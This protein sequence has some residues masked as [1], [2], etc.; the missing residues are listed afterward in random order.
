MRSQYTSIRTEVYPSPIISTG[1]GSFT[2]AVAGTYYFFLS[3][4]NRVGLCELSTSVSATVAA[5]GALSITIPTTARR[6]GEDIQRFILSA[7]TVNDPSAAVMVAAYEG[8][9]SDQVSLA[10]LPATLVLNRD[11]HLKLST[12]VANPTA[13]P[14]GVNLINGM[15]RGVSSLGLVYRY[16]LG[17]VGAADGTTV[18][19]PHTGEFWIRQGYSFSTYIEDTFNVGG[20]NQDIS[21]VDPAIV[22]HPEYPVDGSDGIPVRFT[23]AND[24]GAVVPAGTRVGVSVEYSGEDK[25]QYFSS[26]L[27][28][29]FEGYINLTTGELD[30]LAADGIGNMPG[31]GLP[32]DYQARKSNLLLQKDLPANYG[33]AFKLYPRFTPLQLDGQVADNTTVRVRPFLYDQA[34]AFS[35]YDPGDHIEADA[36]AP[37]KRRIVPNGLG[38]VAKAL[39]GTGFV[40]SFSFKRVSASN[41][42]GFALNTDDQQVVIDHNG[43]V[44]VLTG[45]IPDTMALRA[46]VGTI[47]GEGPASPYSSSVSLDNTKQL[48]VAITYPTAVRGDYPDVIAANSNGVFNGSKVRIYVRNSSGT[49]KY[50]DQTITPGLASQTFT[51]TGGGT[52]I[53]A[54][55]TVASDFGL[56]S[57]T[58]ASYTSTAVTAASTWATDTYTVAIAY[59][60]ESTVTRIS[61]ATI[62]GCIFE[63]DTDQFEADDRSKYWAQPVATKAALRSVPEAKI[64][65]SQARYVAAENNPYRYSASD[66]STDDDFNVIKPSWKDASDPGRWRRDDSS[67]WIS[68]TIDP[69]SSDGET[70]DF[71]INYTTGTYF[72]KTGVSTWT[73]RGKLQGSKWFTG[74]GAPASSLGSLTDLYLNTANSDI[75]YKTGSTTWTLQANIKGSPGLTNRGTWNSATAYVPT[76]FIRYLGSAYYCVQ[77]NTNINPATDTLETYWQLYVQKGDDGID[78]I[79]GVDGAA[80]TIAIG[81]VTTLASGS[82][83]TVNN[84]GTSNAAV[85]DFGI[86]QG[87]TGPAGSVTSSAGSLVL[88]NNATPP[89][90]TSTQTAIYSD[91]LGILKFIKD[92]L[93][94]IFAFTNVSQLYT[95]AQTVGTYTLTD[96]ATINIDASLS[97]VFKV[98]L[99]GNRT[100]ANATNLSD[101]QTIVLLVFQDSTGSRTITWGSNYEFGTDGPP[102]LTITA[103]KFDIL[104]FISNGTKLY[105]CG[106]KQGMTP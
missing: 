38:L 6:S 102:T 23:I 94:G 88:D 70:G 2:S 9:D 32:V 82:S 41:V 26:L 4:E 100:F 76:D 99:G 106:I 3:A 42:T 15:L 20:C 11:E 39:E 37:G 64:S 14:T 25:S 33:Y 12:T 73:E 21:D 43:L 36:E 60:F 30:T 35:E 96:G 17:Y 54:L 98:T 5:G 89:T 104:T 45:S 49:I 101:G 50:F 86:P 51:L 44:Y 69:V 62:D 84:S 85:L 57:A 97:N 103:S 91:A 55:P 56:Y 72:E 75:Y 29:V 78:G 7:A 1:S 46:L 27:K 92:S 28:I 68:S 34:G 52:T 8:Y 53:A 71:W 61:H 77:A 63:R 13:L 93:V 90:T 66:T 83:A 79:D 24:S 16:Q 22:K 10:P 18:L 105:F 48:S 95:K 59:L 40:D 87:A 47:D 65:D 19:E 81:T 67:A 74:S 80:A 31:V 58:S